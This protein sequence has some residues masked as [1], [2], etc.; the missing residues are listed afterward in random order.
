MREYALRETGRP[1]QW[2]RKFIGEF[3]VTVA[4]TG[5]SP[6]VFWQEAFAMVDEAALGRLL[7]S[8]KTALRDD[9][10]HG[11]QIFDK[12]YTLDELITSLLRALKIHAEQQFGEP[13]NEVVLGRP[14][15]F[16]EDEKIDRRAE[17]VLYKSARCAGFEK[18]TFQPEPIGAMYLHHT[19]S[20]ARQRI[21]VFDFGGGTLD[22]TIADVGGEAIPEIL[23]THGVLVGGDDLDRRLMEYLLKYFG[24]GSKFRNQPFPYEIL[25]KLLNWQTMPDVSRP[26]YN[27][28]LYD[29]R[30]YGTNKKAIAALDSLVHNKHGFALFKEI[31]RVKKALS[32][33]KKEILSFH[34]DDI[35]IKEVISRS[36]FE[37]LIKN[38]VAKVREGLECVLEKANVSPDEID[39]VLRTGGSSQ[40][41]IFI[42]MLTEKFGDDK[43][44]EMNPLAS[45]VGGLA[46]VA[47]QERGRK[48]T[49]PQRYVLEHEIDTIIQN[50]QAASE[51]LYETY[52]F[53]IHDPFYT[54]QETI[55]EKAPLDLTRLP[56]IRTAQRDFDVT[57]D[58]F[59]TFDLMQ[60]ATIYIA[61]TAS[62]TQRPVWLQD[63]DETGYEID[64]NDPWVGIKR[65]YV[66]KRDFEAGKITLGG[67]R[68][69]GYEGRVNLNYGVIVQVK[70]D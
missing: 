20:P 39:I 68:V 41:P 12:F 55:V 52:I 36:L 28:V 49:Y 11:T 27:E 43:M 59:L 37:R 67:T 23:G 38:E 53:N 69:D 42:N 57:A 35:Q 70:T 8:V 29:F 16:S 44:R 45:I 61:Y 2:R 56:A 5:S 48:P 65:Y 64:T 3:E 21:L 47:H 54:D 60:P 66:Y 50:V 26:E 4:G 34:E 22:F 33:Q 1:V 9:F 6:I 46:I 58:N 14:V 32:M 63:F 30:N 10:Y 13:C 51:H 19:D 31:E 24:A 17:E 62:A 15:R 40:I 7:Q 18:I 25:D